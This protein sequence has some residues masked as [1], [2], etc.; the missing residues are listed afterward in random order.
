MGDQSLPDGV[1][2]FLPPVYGHQVGGDALIRLSDL[3]AIINQAR[4]QEWQ[5]VREALEPHIDALREWEC[6]TDLPEGVLWDRLGYLSAA[7]SALDNPEDPD[8]K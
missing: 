7:L 1:E 6:N 5:R 4:S 3:P 8:G 2:Q